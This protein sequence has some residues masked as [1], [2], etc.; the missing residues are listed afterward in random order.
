MA[1]SPSPPG[2]LRLALAGAALASACWSRDPD[3]PAREALARELAE[4]RSSE[5]TS[6][7][8]DLDT[9][10]R[11]LAEGGDAPGRTG[12]VLTVSRVADGHPYAIT[13]QVDPPRHVVYLATS[14]LMSLHDAAGDAGVVLLL[15]N[16]AAL[17][18]EN[19]EGKLQL[20]PA[21]GEVVLSIELETDDGLGHRTF[22]AAVQT[23]V[24]Q[25]GALRPKLIGAAAGAEL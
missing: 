5:V 8:P 16:M 22:A 12:E 9:L 4:C 25:A 18:Y 15:T 2:P 10:Q 20:N 17:N 1:R 21:S 19:M 23:L 11:W 14:G 7:A 3:D 13:V 6:P 24:D